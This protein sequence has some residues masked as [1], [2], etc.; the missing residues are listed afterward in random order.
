M[1]FPHFK[2]YFTQIGRCY[3]DDNLKHLIPVILR[4]LQCSFSKMH[5]PQKEKLY[6][7]VLFY[8]FIRLPIGSDHNLQVVR[9]VASVSKFY[10]LPPDKE[11]TAKGE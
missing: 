4:R 6:T 9:S 8:I 7:L 10:W 1:S 11:N 3:K 2:T 5:G